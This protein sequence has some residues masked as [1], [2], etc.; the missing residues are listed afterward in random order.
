SA[1]ATNTAA[2]AAAHS[3]FLTRLNSVIDLSSARFA[4]VRRWRRMTGFADKLRKRLA[5]ADGRARTGNA[6]DGTIPLAFTDPITGRCY[7]GLLTDGPMIWSRCNGLCGKPVTVILLH[8]SLTVGSVTWL[9]STL[10]LPGLSGPCV[11]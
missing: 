1:P 6:C 10:V 5:P 4:F 7:F 8:Q 9:Q 11:I 3:H 2:L